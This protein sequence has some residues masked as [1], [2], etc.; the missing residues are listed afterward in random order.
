MK[1]KRFEDILAWQRARELNKMI[2]TITQKRSF[3]KDFTMID[4]LSRASISIA[5]NIAF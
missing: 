1:I 3:S 4:Q 2:Y 5:S